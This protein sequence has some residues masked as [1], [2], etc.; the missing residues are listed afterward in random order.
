MI[1]LLRKIYNIN[2]I[3]VQEAGSLKKDDS[4]SFLL[5]DLNIPL[6][7]NNPMEPA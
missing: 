1:T 6:D 5:P 4:S 7:N 2:V 3:Y